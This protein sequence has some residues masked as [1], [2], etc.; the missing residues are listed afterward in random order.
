MIAVV[1]KLVSKVSV[2]LD[3]VKGNIELVF[4]AVV[5]DSGYDI[6]LIP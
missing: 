4:S 1:K 2:F 3:I 6:A 5:I